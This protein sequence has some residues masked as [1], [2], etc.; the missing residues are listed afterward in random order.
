MPRIP[1]NLRERALGM[2]GAG[3]TT[4]EVAAPVGASV[5]SIRSLRRRFAQTGSTRDLPRSGR[6]RVTSR[7]QDR[8]ILN[9][10]LRDRFRTATA[11]A[12]VTPGTH[13]NRISAQTVRNRLAESGLHGRRPY[14]GSVLT[15]CHRNNREQWALGH[16]NWTRQRWR[17]ILFTDESRFALSRGDGRVR[18][19]RRRNE[20]YAD[21]CVL[22][23]D[24]FGGGGSVMVWGG[25]AYGYRTR[26]V[27]IDG[28][29]NAQKYREDILG[30]H[31]VPLLQTHK[32]ITTLQQDNATSHVARVNIQFLQN[33]NVD[34]IDDWPSKSPDLNPI[35]HLWDNLDR[36]VRRRPNPP[37]NVNDLRAALLEEWN[38][39]PQADINR[40][41]LSMRRL[42]Q[43][44]SIARGGHTRY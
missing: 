9:Q 30:P 11:T 24:R 19:Y 10:H 27:V 4:A 33:H 18:L 25:I 23:R 20:R 5:Q 37:N 40:L 29:L 21:C 36:R 32:V 2:L 35:E 1:E 42:C 3:C 28:N 43:A 41:V 31:V 44:V 26:L 38:N 22:Q 12:A 17:T 13:N 7:A 8:Y 14:V 39:I 6:P 34:F 15:L 16:I